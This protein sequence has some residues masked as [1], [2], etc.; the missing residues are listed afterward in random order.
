[1]K[2]GGRFPHIAVGFLQIA[3]IA[4]NF[5]CQFALNKIIY[6]IFDSRKTKTTKLIL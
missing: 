4:T 1:V 5:L 6:T 3:A 2:T